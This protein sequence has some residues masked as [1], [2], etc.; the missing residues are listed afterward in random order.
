[1]VLLS[2]VSGMLCY[3][4]GM[5]DEMD[6]AHRRALLQRLRALMDKYESNPRLF[7]LRCIYCADT[8]THVVEG[9]M[10][11]DGLT[12]RVQNPCCDTHTQEI[13][14]WDA[15][16]DNPY[17]DIYCLGF[18]QILDIFTIKDLL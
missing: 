15:A 6:I 7:Q 1:M 5:D 18:S 14:E 12:I 11:A 2:I 3:T 9:I 13:R 16:S 4:S 10:E 17:R 8:A